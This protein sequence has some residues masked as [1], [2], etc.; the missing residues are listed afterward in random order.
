[1]CHIIIHIRIPDTTYMLTHA[2]LFACFGYGPD[3]GTKAVRGPN[4]A[5]SEEGGAG[6]DMSS[7]EAINADLVEK[8]CVCVCVCV[9][10]Y[11]HAYMRIRT[12]MSCIHTCLC[13]CVC[14]YIYIYIYIY[15]YTHTHTHIGD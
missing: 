10:T 6:I 9:H 4:A 5:F 1:M 11:M 7:N 13:V 12:C 3:T 8:V 2:G 14:V 15:I